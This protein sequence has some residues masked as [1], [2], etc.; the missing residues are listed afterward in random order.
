[1]VRSATEAF[2][3]IVEAHAIQNRRVVV[4]SARVK[5]PGL[6]AEVEAKGEE[7]VVEEHGGSGRCDVFIGL[8]LYP[9]SSTAAAPPPAIPPRHPSRGSVEEVGREGGSSAPPVTVTERSGQEGTGVGRE[10]REDSVESEYLKN[11]R[12]KAESAKESDGS[13]SGSEDGENSPGDAT[14]RSKPVGGVSSASSLPLG[15][16]QRPARYHGRT[17]SEPTVES[18][19]QSDSEAVNPGLSALGAM[20]RLSIGPTFDPRAPHKQQ[21]TPPR[22]QTA[23]PRQKRRKT[24]G[25]DEDPDAIRP[26]PPLSP[27]DMDA[28]PSASPS[29]TG[30]AFP[31]HTPRQLSAEIRKQGGLTENPGISVAAAMKSH[32]SPTTISPGTGSRTTTSLQPSRASPSPQQRRGWFQRTFT[33]GR[34]QQ[35]QQQQGHQQDLMRNSLAVHHTR[36]TRA[37]RQAQAQTQTQDQTSMQSGRDWRAQQSELRRESGAPA[38][39]RTRSEG[40]ASTE[41]EE[42]REDVERRRSIRSP[43]PSRTGSTAKDGSQD[44]ASEIDKT[45]SREDVSRTASNA[46]PAQWEGNLAE[47]SARGHILGPA[48]VAR[49]QRGGPQGRR[50]R[51]RQQ[52]GI[53]GGLRSMGESVAYDES[54]PFGVETDG[55]RAFVGLAN[56]YRGGM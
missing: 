8:Y 43:E 44:G 49:E 47:H 52:G 11:G 37:Q 16:K 48:V 9:G 39:A 26:A 27:E 3:A 12:E 13:G 35:E 51:Q 30:A 4:M 42:L 36:L 14:G 1:M 29:G 32:Q 19:T 53:L 40:Q 22:V 46:R 2:D 31:L 54:R 6:N 21:P 5:Q 15:K 10:N 20:G 24:K 55:Y 33:S 17:I 56:Y 34:H 41:L 38:R 7:E 28:S 50:R 23:G 45:G 18:K 25:E